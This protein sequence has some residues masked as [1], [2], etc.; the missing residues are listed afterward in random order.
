MRQVFHADVHFVFVFQPV[1]QHFK[2]QLT[3]RTN[4]NFFHAAVQFL[5]N[6]DSTFLCNLCH[7]FYKLLAFHGI[8]WGN[9][10]KVFRRKG[11]NA[12]E[13]ELFIGGT[14]G[15]ANGKDAWVK[16]TDDVTRIGMV[17]NFP[18]LRHQLLWRHQFHLASALHMHNFHATVKFTGANA[19][20]CN[21]V[22]VGLVHIC[23]DFKDKSGEMG[24]H[25]VN[26]TDVRFARQRCRS[27]AQKF[28]QEWFYAEVRQCRAEEYR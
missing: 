6:L 23:L 3:N 10:G 2:L 14:Q 18:L 17:D 1:F 4:D 8:F 28:L 25:R 19:Q 15:V 11:G 12:A 26:F 22:A 24:I 21:T 13:T 7:A 9:T 27:H 20:K 5:K 16:D